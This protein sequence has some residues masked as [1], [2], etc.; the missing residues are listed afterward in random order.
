[1]DDLLKFDNQI[2]LYLR[3]ALKG[4]E[5]K[6]FEEVLRSNADLSREVKFRKQVAEEL[7]MQ[8]IKAVR[9]RLDN[10]QTNIDIET[11]PSPAPSRTWLYILLLAALGGLLFFLGKSFF[12]QEKIEP[13]Q[14]QFASYYEP[15]DLNLGQRGGQDEQILNFE[16]AYNQKDYKTSLEQ[17]S[18]ITAS[19]NDPKWDL[20]KGICHYELKQYEQALFLFEKLHNAHDLLWSDQGTWYSALTL[21]KLESMDQAKNMLL[22]LTQDKDADHY[23]EAKEILERL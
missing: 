6:A 13:R 10:I 19:S 1:M 7:A 18:I 20:Y 8:E 4:A 3:D 21:I 22:Q 5:L 23:R 17:L 16:K 14:Q 15:Y 11:A 12:S 9:K 2:D